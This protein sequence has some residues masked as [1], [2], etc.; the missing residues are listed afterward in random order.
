MIGRLPAD[1]DAGGVRGG[2]PG[3]ALQTSGKVDDLGDAFVLFGKFAQFA[4][5]GQSLV[6]RDVAVV[7]AAG[8]HLGDLVAQRVGIIQHAAYVA[9]HASRLQRAEGH[10]LDHAVLTVLLRH[11]VDDLAAALVAEI[12][13]DIRHA[14]ALR[15]Q[16]A[17]KKQLVF[18]RIDVRYMQRIRDDGARAGAAPRSYGDPV[19]FRIVDKIPDDEEVIHVAHA[20]DD[21][22]LVVQAVSD[23]LRDDVVPVAQSLLAEAP[24]IGLARKAL[25][26]REM[27]QLGHAEFQLHLTAHGD[28]VRAFQR[29]QRIGEQS[30]HLLFRFDEELAALIAQTVLVRHLFRGL[31]AEQK[32]VRFR[33]FLT[34]IVAVVGR[35]QRDAGLLR[36]PK[37]TAVHGLLFRIAVVLQL[38]EIVVRAE[39][40]PVFESGRLRFFIQTAV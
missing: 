35:D 2:V 25:R 33:V 31:D 5:A 30:L 7:L 19:R 9:D 20:A 17:L 29:V 37:E 40:V 10:D 26:H 23:L 28:L 1:Y 27:R 6:Q 4:A 11:V 8:D 12:H 16:E 21:A 38:Q 14:D 39:D 18:E 22:Q 13:V 24:Q 34:D 32:V 36:E 3:Q 15:V